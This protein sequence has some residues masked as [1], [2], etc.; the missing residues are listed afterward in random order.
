MEFFRPNRAGGRPRFKEK[1]IINNP[2]VKLIEAI[3]KE[4]KY[5]YGIEINNDKLSLYLGFNKNYITK[6]YYNIRNGKQGY[7]TSEKYDQIKDILIVFSSEIGHFV[8]E[9]LKKSFRQYED[10]LSRHYLIRSS[11]RSKIYHP[12]LKER[13]FETIN[14][15]EN[16]YFLGVMYSDGYIIEEFDKYRTYYRIGLKAKIE[17]EELIDK[18]IRTLGLNPEYKHR[19]KELQ[20]IEGKFYEVEYFRIHFANQV[21][22]GDLIRQGVFP[23]KSRIIRLPCLNS[24][25]LYSSFLLGCF[26]GDGEQGTSRLWSGSREFLVD[27]KDLF[28]IQ[29]EI[30]FR[31]SNLGSAWGLSLGPKL[32]NAMLDSYEDSIPRKRN[33]LMER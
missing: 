15:N 12:N 24:C 29:N 7:I 30:Q 14:T 25:E 33:R 6:K 27:I 22:A 23:K 31:K 9:E 16:A 19:Y 4:F 2:T 26:D 21:M 8:S 1:D 32:F 18:F 17:D 10:F 13:F 28:G 3:R 20:N 5:I 11:N